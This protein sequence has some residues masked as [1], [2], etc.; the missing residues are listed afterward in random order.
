MNKYAYFEEKNTVE[1]LYYF[2]RLFNKELLNIK[3]EEYSSKLLDQLEELELS[4][5][6]KVLAYCIA[7]TQ[8][9]DFVLKRLKGIEQVKPLDKRLNLVKRPMDFYPIFKEMNVAI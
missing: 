6:V 8:R 2:F 7:K 9:K 1:E 5:E 3:G 4:E